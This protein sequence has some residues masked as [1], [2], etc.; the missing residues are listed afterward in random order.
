MG[1]AISYRPTYTTLLDYTAH[2]HLWTW[3]NKKLCNISFCFSMKCERPWRNGRGVGL[4][5]VELYSYSYLFSKV[6][7]ILIFISIG[8]WMVISIFIRIEF[9]RFTSFVRVYIECVKCHSYSTIFA[10][11]VYLISNFKRFY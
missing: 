1:E 4:E 3:T 7:L 6:I 2:T 10:Y 11:T 8:F 5:R 9:F